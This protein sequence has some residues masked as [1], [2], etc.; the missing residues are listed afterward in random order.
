MATMS[1]SSAAE[2]RSAV[3]GVLDE[4][5]L[6]KIIGQPSNTSLDKLEAEIAAAVSRV[7]TNGWGGQYGHLALVI[8]EAEYRTACGNANMKV[9]ALPEPGLTPNGLTNADTQIVKA[10]KYA[11]HNNEMRDYLTMLAVQ[12][13]V[14]QHIT[15]LVDKMY[16]EELEEKYV[17]YKKKKIKDIFTHLRTEWCTTTTLEKK[18]ALTEFNRAWNHGTQHVTKYCSN[19]DKAQTKCDKAGIIKDDT[20]KV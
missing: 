6:T 12:D 3:Q 1:I 10:K 13:Q 17:G 19:L 15:Q 2:I 20:E 14:V 18:D 11:K 9:D 7:M 8:S 5:N 16:L 4:S